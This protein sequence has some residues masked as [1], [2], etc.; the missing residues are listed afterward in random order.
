[1]LVLLT[2]HFHKNFTTKSRWQVVNRRQKVMLVVGPNKNQLELT[3]KLLQ[4]KYCESSIKIIIFKLIL[5][6]IKIKG[7]KVS[8]ILFLEYINIYIY[9]YCNI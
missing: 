1:M 4:W 7:F 2:Q 5:D 8:K 6:E 9:I 3:T